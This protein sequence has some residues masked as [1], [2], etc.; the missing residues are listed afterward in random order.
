MS[1][2]AT[3]AEQDEHRR[4]WLAERIGHSWAVEGKFTEDKRCTH[5]QRKYGK[6]A[7]LLC[8]KRKKPNRW[9]LHWSRAWR[10]RDRTF[11]KSEWTSGTWIL[12]QIRV[13]EQCI[14]NRQVDLTWNR[15]SINAY[16]DRHWKYLRLFRYHRRLMRT[17]WALPASET[18]RALSG[19]ADGFG[20]V[21]DGWI[22]RGKNRL[23]A[24]ARRQ[25]TL[26][27]VIGETHYHLNA[28]K[29]LL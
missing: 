25:G 1:Q 18:S 21:N 12:K 7:G 11:E 2:R 27:L 15:P 4:Q 8:P 26:H 19:A 3:K 20:R 24:E 28:D 23:L 6:A 13:C 17:W 10:G 5:C 9:R 16:D 22:T 14:K 29:V